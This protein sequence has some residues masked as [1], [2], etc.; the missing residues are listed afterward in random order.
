MNFITTW[1]ENRAKIKHIR[2]RAKELLPLCEQATGLKCNGHLK[3]E[4]LRKW[5]IKLR[6][7]LDVMNSSS[8]SD[9]GLGVSMTL[10]SWYLYGKLTEGAR[11][12][13]DSERDKISIQLDSYC[14]GAR[15]SD[16][17]LA[18]EMIHK[19][20][21]QKGKNDPVNSNITIVE[22]A[23]T[24]YGEKAMRFIYPSFDV[25][26]VR[27][28]QGVYKSG[29]ELF[30]AV[31]SVSTDPLSVISAKPPGKCMVTF[32]HNNQKHEFIDDEANRPVQYAERIS[33]E[34]A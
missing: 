16:Y 22:G 34:A 7:I 29:Y 3:I 8:K 4:P 19:I 17:V 13:Q 30:V 9:G 1:R 27:S 14:M 28:F 25:K 15:E 21:R 31:S 12:L 2:T 23:A 26:G 33:R 5:K 6:C 20:L 11:G 32:Y 10:A 24:F 18:H